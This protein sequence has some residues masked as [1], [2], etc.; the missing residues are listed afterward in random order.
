MKKAAYDQERQ[1]WEAAHNITIEELKRMSM[2]SL[3]G[4]KK[5]K[6]WQLSRGLLVT[7]CA[8]DFPDLTKNMVT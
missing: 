7:R 2:E 5:S 4:K 3:D 6:V 1:G 8:H